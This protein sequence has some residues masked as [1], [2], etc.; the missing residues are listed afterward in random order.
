MAVAAGARVLATAGTD[1]KCARAEELGAAAAAN[2][3]TTDI[4][5]WARAQTGGAGVDMVFE[6]VGPAL[7]EAPMFSLGVRGRLVNCGNRGA[8]AVRGSEILAVGEEA[9]LLARYEPAA[10]AGGDRV[11][12]APGMVNSHIDITGAAVC[13]RSGLPDK[14]KFPMV[15][16]QPGSP[17]ALKTAPA[18]VP[19]RTLQRWWRSCRRIRRESPISPGETLPRR[20]GGP[21]RLAGRGRCCGRRHCAGD[22]R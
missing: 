13:A 20:R 22:R 9:D 15:H 2:N 21:A 17:G 14:A 6:H 8:V 1:E 18:A 19:H 5:G 11:V 16:R 3:R 7:W 10:L 12:A 4:A